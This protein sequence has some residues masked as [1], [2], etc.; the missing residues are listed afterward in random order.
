MSK[1]E[2]VFKIFKVNLSSDVEEIELPYFEK[3]Y[4]II[5]NFYEDPD[6]VNRYIDE[7]ATYELFKGGVTG[8]LNGIK[9]S[10][11]RHSKL[12][13]SLKEVSDVIMKV[14]G[15]RTLR[16]DPTQ[17]LTNT[18][19]MHD[20]EWNNWKDNYW[21]PHLDHGWTCLIYLNKD[22]CEG[23]NLY[24]KKGFPKQMGL[25]KGL[26]NVIR[27]GAEANAEHVQPWIPKSEWYCAHNMESKYNRAV[28]FPSR[29]YHGQNIA[30][31]RWFNEVRRNQ[32]IFMEI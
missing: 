28:I 6:E 21:W 10:D 22:G 20:K 23:T 8:S 32:V 2:N 5:D 31:D 15:A 26:D 11:K 3:K 9:F 16:S 27:K 1:E 29:I 24:H 12:I 19:Q 14:C 17:L 18:F 4:F 13:P 30:S 25:V 7:Y